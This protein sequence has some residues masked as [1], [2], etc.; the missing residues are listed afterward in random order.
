MLLEHSDEPSR[1]L[2]SSSKQT[3]KKNQ[4]DRWLPLFG[5]SKKCFLIQKKFSLKSFK[6]KAFQLRFKREGAGF[7]MNKKISF[8]DVLILGGFCDKGWKRKEDIELKSLG[9]FQGFHF[10]FLVLSKMGKKVESFFSAGEEKNWN[11]K[12]VIFIS[13]ERNTFLP[14]LVLISPQQ[15]LCKM[16]IFILVRQLL[17]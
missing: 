17:I 4:L 12:I 10:K 9:R 11:S 6:V 16:S 1:R 5:S 3:S 7:L 13:D 8:D 14:F 15:L 2:D